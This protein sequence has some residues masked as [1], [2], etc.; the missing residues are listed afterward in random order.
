LPCFLPSQSQ[1]TFKSNLSTIIARRY[2]KFGLSDNQINQVPLSVNSK[3]KITVGDLDC[4]L[5]VVQFAGLSDDNRQ[6]S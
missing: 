3:L 1:L 5:V 4:Q 6:K 2:F